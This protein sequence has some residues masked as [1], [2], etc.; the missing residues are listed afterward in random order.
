MLKKLLCCLLLSA[1]VLPAGAVAAHAKTAPGQEKNAPKPQNTAQ[2]AQAGTQKSQSTAQKPLHIVT[3]TQVLADI[4]K[5]ITGANAKVTALVPKGA[6]PQFY[7]P[8]PKQL[9][10]IAHSDVIFYN[11]A[12]YE[13]PRLL[14]ALEA[15]KPAR[16]PSVELVGE[17]VKHSAQV[18]ALAT[19]NTLDAIWL[20]MRIAPLSQST[21]A[22]HAAG[23]SVEISAT[24]VT[25][26]GNLAAY[27]VG[28]FGRPRLFWNSGDGFHAASGYAQDTVKL[29]LAAHTHLSWAF[30]KPGVY[31]LN[32]QAHLRAADG[33][34][35]YLGADRVAFAVGIDPASYA[36]QSGRM[37][38]ER[39][40]ADISLDPNTGVFSVAGEILHHGAGD[41]SGGAG[42]AGSAAGNAGNSA[43][44]AGN[45][46]AQQNKHGHTG[47]TGHNHTAHPDHPHTHDF[48]AA[49][50]QVVFAVPS[51][52][53]Q[54]IPAQHYEFLGQP[55]TQIYQLP[56]AVLGRSM[57]GQL[58]P[59]I[60]QNP[61]NAVAVTAAI[62]EQLTLVDAARS[63]LWHSR[64]QVY[65]QQLTALSQKLQARHRQASG[66]KQLVT[67]KN[68]YVYFAQVYGYQVAGT[69]RRNPAVAATIADQKRLLQTLASGTI[70]AVF[71]ESYYDAD[72][73][74]LREL[75]RDKGLRVCVLYDQSLDSQ[76]NSYLALLKHNSKTVINCLKEE[77]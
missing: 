37:V 58:D 18:V 52:T 10:Q 76:V 5:N 20:G 75:A 7:E 56:Q 6:D 14:R 21:T 60:L 39:G 66:T 43:D 35:T 51:R 57:H 4:V 9:R 2:A 13:D 22:Q 63:G 31:V 71:V 11:Y 61:A 16:T 26:P 33:S 28:S 69:S 53:L 41:S 74:T 62:A 27:V 73:N 40:H 50:D 68:G 45:A 64:Q 19:D 72:S 24:K 48:H 23:A 77:K 30:S 54:A 46:A 36:S 17:A 67:A 3:T 32:L 44:S 65:A 15:A 59:H 25:G 47:H 34:R 70:P 55:G 29:P 42:G 38:L 8:Q 49:L 1:L 12:Q